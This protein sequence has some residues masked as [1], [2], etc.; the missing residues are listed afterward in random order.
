MTL[1]KRKS[2]PPEKFIGFYDVVEALGKPGCAICRR[3]HDS[4]RSAIDSLLYESV[5]DPIIRDE[6]RATKGFCNL[7]ARLALAN[8]DAFGLSIIYEDLVAN[9]LDELTRGKMPLSETSGCRICQLAE[10][11]EQHTLT[12]CRDYFDDRQFCDALQKADAFCARHFALLLELLPKGE[13]RERLW[14]W[15]Q[16]KL[17]ALRHQLAEFIR[18]VDYRFH[19]EEVTE[20][21][22]NAWQRAMEW[23]VGKL[24]LS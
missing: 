7:H 4:A 11:T 14:Q 12:T 24:R 13:S 22:A 3:V 1:L 21:E 2:P 8:G 23:F 15:E 19:H 10:E 9:Q 17:A 18:K 6:L 5:T 16:E 20:K